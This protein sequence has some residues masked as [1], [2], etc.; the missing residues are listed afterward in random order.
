MPAHLAGRNCFCCSQISV[1]QLWSKGSFGHRISAELSVLF[2]TGA[3]LPGSDPTGWGDKL[4]LAGSGAT[5]PEIDKIGWWGIALRHSKLRRRRLLVECVI[6][7][8]GAELHMTGS[9]RHRA[10]LLPQF[11]TATRRINGG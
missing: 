9:R 7:C 10:S 5:V 2:A 3:V 4:S 6:G 11:V 8:V 1:I